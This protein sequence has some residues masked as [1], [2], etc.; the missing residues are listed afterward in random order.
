MFDLS[1]EKVF[2]LLVV[3][4]FVLGP[5]RLPSAA[6]WLGRTLRQVKSFA[7]DAE[8][9]LRDEVGA[10]YDQI[11]EPLAQLRAPSQE[12]R[13]LSDP[14]GT[15]LRGL[16][17]APSASPSNTAASSPR[18][19]TGSKDSGGGLATPTEAAPPPVDFDAT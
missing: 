7:G 2:V 4:L 11:R 18:I 19:P 1:F 3:A 17:D 10:D 13:A 5:E 9:R 6:A 14:R 16:L 8:R 15:L 12:L